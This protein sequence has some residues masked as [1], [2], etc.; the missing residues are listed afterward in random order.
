MTD[1]DIARI[2]ADFPALHQ[3]VKGRLPAYLDSACTTLRP[4]PVISAMADYMRRNS[5]CHGR[6][7]HAFGREATRVVAE[8][9]EATRAFLGA[10]HADEVIFVRGCTEALNLVAECLPLG[11]GDTVL[12]TGIEHNSNLLP[13]QGLARRRG[14]RHVVLPLDPARGFDMEAF[15]ARL[16]EGVRLVSVVHVSN[17]CGIELPVAQICREAHRAGAW[18][19]VDGAQSVATHAI[20]V[21]AMDAD[22]F[23]FSFHKAF[24]P[25]GIGALYGRR[26]LLA[27]MPAWQVGGDT[28]EDVT[29]DTC[30]WAAV[31][32]RFE[33]GV[34]NTTGAVGAAAAIAWL[35]G[36]GQEHVLAHATALNERATAALSRFPRVHVIGPADARLRGAVLNFWV[37][38][39]DSRS[40]A[41]LLD[42]RAGVM[43]RYGKHCVHAWYHA[44][45]TP[46]SVRASF[47]IYNTPAD[48]DALTDTLGNVLSM[49]G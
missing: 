26:E 36:I 45:G 17:L 8:A 24:G 4:E 3:P 34:A 40:L 19:L 43:V 27:R 38:G 44:S 6:A 21:V 14:V 39:L 12:T 11:T 33:A 13:W 10:A 2:R 37:D 35:R 32:Q 28:V 9:R 47:T 49:I 15:R 25:E 23:A 31:P 22:F 30:T 29:Y 41:G 46:D 1:A 7:A 42:E 16:R 18:V 20:D 5:G 48:V